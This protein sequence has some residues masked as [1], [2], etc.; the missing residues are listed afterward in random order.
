MYYIFVGDG[1]LKKEKVLI[2]NVFIFLHFGTKLQM[3]TKE[4]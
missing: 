3:I 4:I 2:E 1:L